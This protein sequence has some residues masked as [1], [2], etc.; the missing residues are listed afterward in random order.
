MLKILF[1]KKSK[2]SLSVIWKFGHVEKQKLQD[3]FVELH[4]PNSIQFFF[5]WLNFTIFTPNY[6]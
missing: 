2:M 3:D 1:K 4:Q 5:K 6:E